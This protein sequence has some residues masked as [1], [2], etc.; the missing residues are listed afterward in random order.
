[1][2]EF[3]RAA[4]GGLKPASQSVAT[5]L[6]GGVD[7]S[8]LCGL[9]EQQLDSYDTYSSSYPFEDPEKDFEKTYALS[10]AAALSTRHNFFVPNSHDFLT[11]VVEGLSNAE[12]PLGSS[13]VRALAPVVQAC[14]S[15]PS[16][17]RDSWSGGRGC[18]GTEFT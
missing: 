2:T 14:D 6:S 11:G 16:H 1:M 4:V 3:L 5:L 13:A 17:S 18:V 7:S 12:T 10:A 8:I 15:Q 9:V